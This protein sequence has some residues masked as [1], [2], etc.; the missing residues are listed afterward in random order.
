VDDGRTDLTAETVRIA[1][2]TGWGWCLALGTSGCWQVLRTASTVICTQLDV[3]RSFGIGRVK[4][5]STVG[6]D[7]DAAEEVNVGF[8]VARS[9]TPLRHFAVSTR[10]R[11]RPFL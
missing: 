11:S 4:T 10:K 8:P 7:G 3:I 9:K 1:S 2:C 6:I 5:D